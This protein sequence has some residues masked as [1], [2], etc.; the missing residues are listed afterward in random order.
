MTPGM[1]WPPNVEALSC[2]LLLAMAADDI[3]FYAQ[4]LAEVLASPDHTIE[5][6]NMMT[7]TLANTL[8]QYEPDFA[9]EVADRLAVLLDLMAAGNN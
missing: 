8:N 1:D 5:V 2:R 3:H 4:A 6:I 9:R 7:C